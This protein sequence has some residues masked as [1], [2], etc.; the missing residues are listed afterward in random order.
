MN[1]SAIK[2]GIAD[3]QTSLLPAGTQQ[4]HS[5]QHRN[6]WGASHPASLSSQHLPCPQTT[7]GKCA[8]ENRVQGT[9]GHVMLQQG[10]VPCARQAIMPCNG[11]SSLARHQHMHA[12][13]A[14]HT[15]TLTP[16][17]L[18]LACQPINGCLNTNATCGEVA[19]SRPCK[20]AAYAPRG[21]SAPKT[22]QIYF[23]RCASTKICQHI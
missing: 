3:M 2:G 6:G 16:A 18:H 11:C 14:A 5:L 17:D 9:V 13:K 21:A 12:G 19:S 22:W 7:R 4:V 10:L 20:A 1:T 8:P 23:S 15:A